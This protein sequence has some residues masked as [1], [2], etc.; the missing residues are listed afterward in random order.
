M[1]PLV[2]NP[3]N[4][5]LAMLGMVE[6]NGHPYSWSAITNGRYD[7]DLMAACGYPVIPQYLGAQPPEALGIEGAKVT[8]IWCDRR[9]DAEKV[10]RCTFIDRVVDRPEDVIGQVD[11]VIIPTDIGGEHVERARPFIEA[12]LPVF[13]DKPLTDNERDLKQ[14]ARW[15]AQG[16]PILS[17]SAMRYAREFAAL[18]GRL[19]E[20]GEVRLITVTMA[21]SWERYGIHALES[22]YGLLPP[23]G[24]LDVVNTGDAQRN[25]VHARHAPQ[26]GLASGGGPSG[27]AAAS[28]GVDVLLLV[29]DDLYGGFGHVTVTGTQGRLDARFEDTFHAF[30]AQLAAFIHYLRS[31]TPPVDFAETIEQMKMVIAGIRSRQHGG[32]R[33]RLTEISHE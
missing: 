17:T 15:Q 14:F 11:A 26:S 25:V 20:V 28:G 12:G 27:S 9:D 21:K 13:I 32:R 22:V 18:R 6:G 2:P 19:G 5:R 4:I 3:R 8:H 31:G 24:W 23:G 1:T 29:T 10:A 33:V 7:A 30:K 16:R